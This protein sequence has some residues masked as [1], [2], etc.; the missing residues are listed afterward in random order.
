MAENQAGIERLLGELDCKGRALEAAAA[1][2]AK[3]A[4]VNDSVAEELAAEG[5]ASMVGDK[6]MLACVERSVSERI[7]ALLEGLGTAARPPISEALEGMLKEREAARQPPEAIQQR[8]SAHGE[9]S[10]ERGSRPGPGHGVRHVPISMC[11]SLRGDAA[12]STSPSG[13]ASLL[14]SENAGRSGSAGKAAAAAGMSPREATLGAPVPLVATASAAPAVATSGDHCFMTPV[15]QGVRFASTTPNSFWHPEPSSSGIQC[16][17]GSGGSAGGSHHK[18]QKLDDGIAAVPA[19]PSAPNQASGCKAT[20]LTP[21]GTRETPRGAAQPPHRTPSTGKTLA[22]TINPAVQADIHGGSSQNPRRS[23][24]APL[25]ADRGPSLGC[26]PL[27]QRHSP[28]LKTELCD[29]EN[30]GSGAV[31]A[32]KEEMGTPKMVCSA[33]A[34]VAPGGDVVSESSQ[35]Q[36]SEEL[37]GSQLGLCS[38]G[39]SLQFKPRRHSV[40]VEQGPAHRNRNPG[41]SAGAIQK[42]HQ[43]TSSAPERSLSLCALASPRGGREV[44][45]QLGPGRQG[46]PGGSQGPGWN[47]EAPLQEDGSPGVGRPL[48]ATLPWRPSCTPEVQCTA[49]TAASQAVRSAGPSPPHNSTTSTGDTEILPQPSGALSVS[50]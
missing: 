40:L 21:H 43:P 36:D 6:R 33:P 13:A 7:C 32:G 18:K 4:E 17:Q 39:L 35:E 20:S 42:A 26:T 2:L 24:S 10:W 27:L 50:T 8:P 9:A 15:P 5:Y 25:P 3:Y 37:L 44:Q 46:R 30:L 31:P 22:D 47:A 45:L 11:A 16:A 23:A 28:V 41:A 14:S 12:P 49:E 38:P 1:E 34:L 48:P 29:V 19:P